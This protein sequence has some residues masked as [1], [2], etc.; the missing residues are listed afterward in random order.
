M[1]INSQL[2]KHHY[3]VVRDFLSKERAQELADAFSHHIE[4]N[5]AI[6]YDP[7]APTSPAAYNFRPF[8]SE[9]LYSHKK[10]EAI[11]ETALY[12]TYCYARQYRNN[13]SIQR[14]VDREA[15]QISVT[16]C[17]EKDCDWRFYVRDGDN[18]MPAEVELE[19]GDAVI[20]LGEIAEHWRLGYGGKSHTQLF[21]HYV[22]AYGANYWAYFDKFKYNPNGS[23][24]EKFLP[25]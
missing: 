10:M 1:S 11:T 15:C 19:P 24:N 23:E 18:E 21:L 20:Y 4:N 6:A 3:L 9:L 12:P 2:A 8:L 22:R 5:G 7:M 14:H 13:A 17:L 16:V 25:K